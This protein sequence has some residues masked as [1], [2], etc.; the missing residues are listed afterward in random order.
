M[1]N[2]DVITGGRI[3]LQ[4]SLRVQGGW[5]VSQKTLCYYSKII[6]K[7]SI[8][9]KQNNNNQKKKNQKENLFSGLRNAEHQYKGKISIKQEISIA[10]SSLLPP[11]TPHPGLS[12]NM[13]HWLSKQKG[14]KQLC[15]L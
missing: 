13:F 5:K 8:T 4:K 14:M 10:L 12:L 2:G 9:E 6:L 7:L 3:Q 15:Q 1:A 11:A